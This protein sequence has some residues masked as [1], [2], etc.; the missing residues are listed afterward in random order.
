MALIAYGGA[1]RANFGDLLEPG[2]RTIF[3]DQF[4]TLPTVYDK[5][6]KV[7]SSSKQQEYDSSVSGFG[8]LVETTEG[9]PIT[10]EDPIQGYDTSYVH[11]KYAKGFKITR[12]MNSYVSLIW[13]HIISN[14]AN[15]WKIIR[16]IIT[17][18]VKILWIQQLIISRKGFSILAG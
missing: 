17:P 18:K 11:K 3:F 8:Q 12:E 4:Q 6:F 7:N 1:T 16:T 5:V 14:L 13:Q 15:C 2:F 9:A 10:Y